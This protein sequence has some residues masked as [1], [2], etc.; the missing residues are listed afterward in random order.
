MSKAT[1]LDGHCMNDISV[2]AEK[3][4]IRKRGHHICQPGTGRLW[5]FVLRYLSRWARL[6]SAQRTEASF[7][8]LRSDRVVQRVGSARG[9]Q[10]HC[11]I[12][13]LGDA[14][15][16]NC[17]PS[18]STTGVQLIYHVGL[19]VDSKQVGYMFLRR[20]PS[21]VS[22]MRTFDRG[23]DDR[24]RHPGRKGA[25]EGRWQ[26]PDL[27]SGQLLVHRIVERIVKR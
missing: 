8:V 4:G 18:A 22:R 15:Q 25:F 12:V 10:L 7:T 5:A 1:G 16:I 27:H 21:F 13:G 23:A 9:E 17:N 6:A 14:A 19:I 26:R 20:W 11:S 24:R 3:I 2:E